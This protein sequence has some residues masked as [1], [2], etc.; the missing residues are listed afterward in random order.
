M[1]VGQT[2]NDMD[3]GAIGGIFPRINRT[4]ET[5]EEHTSNH[6]GEEAVWDRNGSKVGMAVV[7][8]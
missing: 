4:G 5:S 2:G 6:G 8:C 7:F 1:G 3:R